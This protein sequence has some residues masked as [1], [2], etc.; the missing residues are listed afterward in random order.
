MPFFH[1]LWTMEIVTV[2]GLTYSDFVI[3]CLAEI[4]RA[5]LLV[6]SF[7]AVEIVDFKKE[8]K[9]DDGVF[10]DLCT[11]SYDM[12]CAVLCGADT[13][14]YGI[15]HKSVIIAD[16]GQLLDVSDMVNAPESYDAGKAYRS[17]KTSAG[18]LGVIVD[19]DIMR[20]ESAKAAALNKADMI[21]NISD[22]DIDNKQILAARAAAL[23]NNVPALLCARNYSLLSDVHGEVKFAS[24]AAVN[25]WTV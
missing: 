24:K 17:Y 1:I 13:D 21:V 19:G 11:L 6:L 25:I 16:R 18:N 14:V 12:N 9:R 2:C 8:I 3:G 4:E 7:G 5:D 23:F 22:K 10:V 15:R 20:A